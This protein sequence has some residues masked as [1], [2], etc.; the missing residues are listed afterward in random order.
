[1]FY[2]EKK[3]D[4]FVLD[5]CG[6]YKND[7]K[8]LESQLNV[9]YK[10]VYECYKYY[11]ENERKHEKFDKDMQKQISLIDNVILEKHIIDLF[12][13]QSPPQKPGKPKIK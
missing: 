9:L 10:A 2:R 1:L 6:Q 7:I 13:I 5:V 4:E 8:L 12:K 3:N 11:R